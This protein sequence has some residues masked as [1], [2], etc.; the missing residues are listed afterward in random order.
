MPFIEL[1]LALELPTRMGLV[2][3]TEMP[4]LLSGTEMNDL[5]RIYNIPEPE[6]YVFSLSMRYLRTQTL[7]LTPEAWWDLTFPA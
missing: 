4:D 6:P 1:T 7:T 2:A 3:M 5:S